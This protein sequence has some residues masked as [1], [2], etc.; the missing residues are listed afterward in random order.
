M[1]VVFN[2]YSVDAQFSS[3]EEFVDTLVDKT[4]PILQTL[5]GRGDL[6]LKALAE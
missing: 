4:I 5:S 1:E 6:L 2:D 3:V